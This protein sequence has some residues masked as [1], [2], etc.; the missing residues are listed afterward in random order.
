MQAVGVNLMS[1][2]ESKAQEVASKYR[3]IKINDGVFNLK[4]KED[5]SSTG[6]D[7]ER[8]AIRLNI[9]TVPAALTWIADA[10]KTPFYIA[11]LNVTEMS[12]GYSG[13]EGWSSALAEN[14][15][16]VIDGENI[17]NLP[18]KNIRVLSA[19]N[20]KEEQERIALEKGIIAEI[21]GESEL[22]NDEISKNRFASAT[23]THIPEA[24]EYDFD[25]SFELTVGLPQDVFN[26]LVENNLSGRT[27]NVSLRGLCGA[28]SS[29]FRHGWARD[30][31]IQA[32]TSVSISIDSIIIQSQSMAKQKQAE[33][34]AIDDEEIH[35]KES[36]SN[37]V[38][39]ALAQVSDNIVHLRSTIVKAAW[40]L[41]IAILIAIL[42]K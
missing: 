28:L 7:I 12:I 37:M 41:S 16:F 1:D 24:P 22:T 19:E 6:F 21:G 15:I 26:K 4:R 35:L 40:I 2:K 8:Q 31:I 18:L 29:S 13:E 14:S 27:T 34:I 33:D 11:H 30:M 20:Y 10:D 25:E 32:D 23:L 39:T 9:D 3:V 42:I 5:P 36:E 17:Q 38:A